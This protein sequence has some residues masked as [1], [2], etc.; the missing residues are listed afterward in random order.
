MA[1]DAPRKTLDDI[2]RELDAEYGEVATLHR[3]SDV[4]VADCPPAADAA[5]GACPVP[6]PPVTVDYEADRLDAAIVARARAEMQSRRWRGGYI[7]AGVIGCLIGQLT[8]LGVMAVIRHRAVSTVG[9]VEAPTESVTAAAPQAGTPLPPAA[10]ETATT[11]ETSRDAP[12][13]PTDVAAPVA[14]SAVPETPPAPSAPATPPPASVAPAPTPAP[15]PNDPKPVP[16]RVVKRPPAVASRLPVA[17]VVPAAPPPIS[18]PRSEPRPLVSESE[19]W[20]KSQEEVRA[21]LSAW[22][23]ASGRA[24]QSIVSDT[25]VFLG[26][27][28]RTARTHVPTRWGGGGV[29]IREQRWERR[30]DGWSIVQDREAWRG[31][32]SS[33]PSDLRS[34]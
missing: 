22:L 28:G 25:V 6:D 12:S 31:E 20:A 32:Q 34:R 21:A 17:P 13:P 18:P 19:N 23:A 2:R 33:E 29:V 27:D 26:A 9:S 1:F 10:R 15:V 8:L 5:A 3:P 4:D 11:S 14:A 7:A 30:A 16:R 24:D